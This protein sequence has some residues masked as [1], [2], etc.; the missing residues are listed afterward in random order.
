M[1]NTTNTVTAPAE[2]KILYKTASY[3][4]LHSPGRWGVLLQG[5]NA[6]RGE[7]GPVTITKKSG[8]TKVE[9]VRVFWTGE[10]SDGTRIGLGEIVRP[11]YWDHADAMYVQGIKAR[12]E[13]K[14]QQQ[15]KEGIPASSPLPLP[16]QSPPAPSFPAP[17]AFAI[18]D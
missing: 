8:E 16:S 4:R 11:T 9:Q 1:L 13:W 5:C 2:P 3:K 18:S 12:Q 14:A 10:G 6:L 15:A 7:V 17:G